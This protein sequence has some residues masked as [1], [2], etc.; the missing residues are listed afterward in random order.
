MMIW[1]GGGGG[2]G[3]GA[4]RESVCE[5]ERSGRREVRGEI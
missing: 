3:K 2:G 1:G 5:I 4:E